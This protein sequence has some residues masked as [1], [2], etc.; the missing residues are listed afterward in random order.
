[1]YY[2]SNKFQL[3]QGVELEFNGEPVAVSDNDVADGVRFT[4]TTTSYVLFF[5]QLN[6][7]ITSNGGKKEIEM[8]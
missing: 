8:L 5:V 3:I 1:M 7:S 2:N 4:A 6:L